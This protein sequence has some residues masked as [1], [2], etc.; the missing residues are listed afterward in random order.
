[1][2]NLLTLLLLLPLPAWSHDL[3]MFA[4]EERGSISI[5][6]YYAGGD[7]AM[8]E[9][10]LRGEDDALLASGETAE[11]GQ[12]SL[13]QMPEGHYLVASTPDGHR[14]RWPLQSPEAEQVARSGSPGATAADPLA[15]QVAM[16]RL[17]LNQF[18]SRL[19]LSDMLAGIAIIFA[20]AGW[21]M[22]W[23]GRKNG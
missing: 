16:L 13:V 6:V 3:L 1:M 15:R 5:T 7:P 20:L 2:K 23:R 8:A 21:L 17:E 22:W 11:D 10:E 14:A 4:F 18:Q 12:I 19:R 9:V